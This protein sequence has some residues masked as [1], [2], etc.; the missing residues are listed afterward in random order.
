VDSHVVVFTPAGEAISVPLPADVPD[1]P[2]NLIELS[3]LDTSNMAPGDYQLA[4]ILTEPGG[5]PLLVGDWH[6]GFHGLLSVERI[7]FALP[8]DPEDEDEDGE[9]DDDQDGDGY[10]EEEQEGDE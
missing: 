5:D 6:E 3:D 8:P 10:E 9:F 7:R 4:V 1:Q 2:V